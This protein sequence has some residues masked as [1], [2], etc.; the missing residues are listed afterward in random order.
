MHESIIRQAAHSL[1]SA[2]KTVFS[3]PRYDER[4]GTSVRRGCQ[5]GTP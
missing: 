4:G 5:G 1:L 3:R 2:D